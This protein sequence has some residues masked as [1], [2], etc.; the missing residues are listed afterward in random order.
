MIDDDSDDFRSFGVIDR[1]GKVMKE[2][3][4]FMAL[5]CLPLHAC[6]I[7]GKALEGEVLEEGTNMPIVGAIVVAR[8]SGTAFSFAESPTVC[9]HVLTTTTDADGKYR[10]HA[11]RKE[12]PLK[13]VRDVRPIVTAHKP[14][15]QLAQR[16]PANN[17]QLQPFAGTREERLRYI[18]HVFGSTGCGA[19]DESEKNL[20]PFLKALQDEVQDLAQTNEEKKLVESIRYASEKIELGY[21]PAQKRHL[22]RVQG[23]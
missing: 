15:Y 2:F 12:S 19:N 13:G 23:K 22:E 9:V 17:P 4:V 20:I 14:G 7:S 16:Y 18:E 6:A 8:W 10:F 3:L 11:W 21:E 1:Q 5:L